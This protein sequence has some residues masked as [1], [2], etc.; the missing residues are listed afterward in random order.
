M[1]KIWWNG[2]IIDESEARI[3]IYDAAFMFGSTVFEMCRSFRKVHF[4]LEEHYER[5]A[6]SASYVRIPFKMT[7]EEFLSAV[8]MITEIN[9]GEFADDDEYRLMIDVTGGLLPRYHEVGPL[10]TNVI[11]SIFPLRW[12]TMGLGK[13]FDEGVHLNITSQ[14]QIPAQ[15][16]DPK[17]KHRSRL[18]FHMALQECQWPLLLDDLGYVTEGPG[19]NFFIVKDE[20]MY[21]PK[22]NNILRGITRRFIF[23]FFPVE[24]DDIT[25]YDAMNADEAFIT[26]TPFCILPVSQ[27][28]GVTIG[29]HKTKTSAFKHLLS[30]WRY[31]TK[32]EIN[33]QIQRWD[34]RAG[35]YK[36]GVDEPMSETV[37]LLRSAE[38]RT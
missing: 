28:N 18:H 1:R 23:D 21:T 12:A 16:L 33:R 25:P 35:L 5:L 3:S 2:N 7:L 13:Y 26:A 4:K 19:Y 20:V 38:A 36:C 15:Y 10:G 30:T 32:V 29:P 8:E 27:I 9:K 24:E 11:I 14:R 17:I 37:L 22:D 31:K 6:R 34:E